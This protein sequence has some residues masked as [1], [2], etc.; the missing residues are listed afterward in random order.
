MTHNIR[1]KCITHFYIVRLRTLYLLTK[2]EIG[3]TLMYLQ[4]I[5]SLFPLIQ[6]EVDRIQ[7]WVGIYEGYIEILEPCTNS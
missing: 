4:V 1:R 6:C 3:F 5:Q 2:S 7:V